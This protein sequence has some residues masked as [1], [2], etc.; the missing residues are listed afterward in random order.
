[1]SPESWTIIATGIALAAF[2]IASNRALKTGLKTDIAKL[3]ERM[4]KIENGMTRLRE[5]VARLEGKMDL[6]LQG[7]R[8]RSEPKNSGGTD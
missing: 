1:M 7:L 5:R 4:G 3:G 6:M 2:I 8:I